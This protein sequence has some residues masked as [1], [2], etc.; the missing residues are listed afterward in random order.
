MKWQHRLQQCIF[1]VLLIAVITVAAKLS[2]ATNT[3][4]DLTSNQR[5]SLSDQTIDLLKSLDQP[6]QI[7]A[8]I[9]PGNEFSPAL[10][11]QLQRYQKYT[12]Q[13]QVD[14]VDPAKAP[15]QVK[16]FNIQ[17]QGEMLVIQGAKTERVQDLSEQSLTNAILRVSRSVKPKLVFITGHGERSAESNANFG[18]SL[19]AN[20][21]IE[22][23]FIIETINLAAEGQLPDNTDVVVIASPDLDWL[24][25]E[26]KL[27]QDYV[28]DGGNLLWLT[29][30][31][32]HGALAEL[33]DALELQWLPGTIIDPNSSLLGI[34]DPTF[35]LLSNFADHSLTRDLP[36]IVLMPGVSA[37][38]S[39]PTETSDWQTIELL[40]TQVETWAE[41]SSLTTAEIQFNEDL[42]L[43]GPLAV[44]LSLEREQKEA[45]ANQRV[46]VIGD[47]DFVSNQ[48]LGNG[49]NQAFANG[50]V[51]WLTAH[52]DLLNIAVKT[53]P[54]N[55]L[56][57]SFTET[58]IIAIGFLFILPALLLATGLMLWWLR[59]KR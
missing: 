55:Q 23:G 17:Q 9:S 45:E 52:D 59:R 3:A 39:T 14:I 25:G 6:T 49:A 11:Q 57:L 16:Q 37:V 12:D 46:V 28:V 43:P 32:Q 50:I 26:V 15:Q 34:D 29:E 41:L 5:H 31:D 33:A 4:F 18:L 38:Q 21:L 58:L 53:T 40:R 8:F 48:F 56:S 19:W 44:S 22:Q 24:P 51:N 7:K 30:P 1:Y 2:L 47:G 20:A 27:I 13:L 54:D 35:A 36:S 42:D 10:Q